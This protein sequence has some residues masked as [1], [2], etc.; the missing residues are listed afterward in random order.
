MV[1]PGRHPRNPVA[2]ALESA[3]GAG[4]SVVEIHKGHRWGKVACD[5]CG[6][7]LAVWSTPKNDDDHAK[8]I[9]RFTA[10]HTH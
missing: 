8:Q 2:Q 5:D 4:L 7:S 9:I 6:V 3:K 10:K 1:S